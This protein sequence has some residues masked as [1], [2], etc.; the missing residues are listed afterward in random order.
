MLAIIIIVFCRALYSWI[1]PAPRA[2]AGILI[3]V[4]LTEW[5]THFVIFLR[6]LLRVT[7][8]VFRRFPSK[9]FTFCRQSWRLNRVC[10]TLCW[11]L[12]LN[13][14]QF[15][16]TCVIIW[17]TLSLCPM[18]HTADLKHPWK[19][20]ILLFTSWTIPPKPT[21][22]IFLASVI[23]VLGNTFPDLEYRSG[24]SSTETLEAML[25]TELSM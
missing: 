13:N 22:Y 1:V 21:H 19:M 15:E 24:S 10:D 25:H 11:R 16:I 6:F 17:V 20:T 9:T 14:Q 18:E 4:W 3:N 8:T 7:R 2:V 12:T 23:R 5:T